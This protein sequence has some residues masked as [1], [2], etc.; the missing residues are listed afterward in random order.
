MTCAA[1]LCSKPA[2]VWSIILRSL[3]SV[4]PCLLEQVVLS[5]SY[6]GMTPAYSD[7]LDLF[8]NIFA[9]LFTG[10]AILKLIAYGPR[11]YFADG[12]NRFDMIIVIGSDI[13]LILAWT[14]AANI[15]AIATVFR[16]FRLG[17]YAVSHIGAM[18]ISA[19]VSA[20]V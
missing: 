15:G 19:C 10:E 13:G 17:R 18:L 11:V 1:F 4:L 14:G 8:N 16:A 6:F 3:C 12:W 5:A 9:F 20:T 2:T 7:M